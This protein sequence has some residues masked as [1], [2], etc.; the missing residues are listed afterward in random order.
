[1]DDTAQQVLEALTTSI[2]RLRNRTVA[3]LRAFVSG[4]VVRK[5]AD[6]LGR[7]GPAPR[8]EK[9]MRSLDSTVVSSSVAGPLWQFIS[10]GATSPLSAVERAEMAQRLTAEL[11]RLK[12]AYR[13]VIALAFFDQL[14]MAEVARRMDTTRPAAS[15]LLI[16]AVD[17]LRQR[18]NGSGQGG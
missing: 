11:A 12:P 1:V 14:C 9:R 2:A 3:G 5:V 10:G 16:R 7:A 18:M 13:E 17:T 6:A 4:V 8:A 15:M